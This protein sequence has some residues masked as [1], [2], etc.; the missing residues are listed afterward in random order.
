M[1]TYL[2]S[3]NAHKAE[4]FAHA[5]NGVEVLPSPIS[6]E[7]DE[8]AD[9]FL[10]NARLKA[11]AYAIALKANTLADDSGLCV[12]ALNG[13]PGIHSQRFAVLPPDID[14][15][16]DR[17]AANNRK[18]LRLLD[19]VPA[20]KRTAHFTCA[21]CL[22]VVNHDDILAMSCSTKLRSAAK[23]FDASGNEITPEADNIDHA[24]ILIEAYA[25]GTILTEKA[26]NEGFGYDPLFFCPDTNCTFAQLTQLQKL[27]VSHRGRAIA[28]LKQ[29]F[30]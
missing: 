11:Q 20:P 10:G 4:E 26:G 14:D 9:S 6:V 19:G 27:E 7:V 29:L 2:A 28:A 22:Y 23:F 21:L 17:T 5:V 1:K 16:P 13:A 18:L 15:D 3:Q 24:E 25:P 8:N 12:D 30:D